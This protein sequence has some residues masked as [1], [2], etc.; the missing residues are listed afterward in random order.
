MKWWEKLSPPLT[1]GHVW[2]VDMFTLCQTGSLELTMNP[3]TSVITTQATPL[4]V[5]YFYC[6]ALKSSNISQNVTQPLLG[7]MYEPT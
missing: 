6:L 4:P 3:R 7:T 1:W 2:M 5:S